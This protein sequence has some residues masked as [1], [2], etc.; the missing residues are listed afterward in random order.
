M[1]CGWNYA[2]LSS[3]K[4]LTMEDIQQCNK[5]VLQT[6][7][8]FLNTK[9]SKWVE[10]DEVYLSVF[11]L[12][13]W[14]YLWALADTKRPSLRIYPLAPTLTQKALHWLSLFCHQVTFALTWGFCA[15]TCMKEDFV[16]LSPFPNYPKACPL[17]PVSA[18]KDP[19]CSLIDWWAA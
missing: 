10:T 1:W 15:C 16:P 17:I 11:G 5:S 2:T 14:W 12:V 18:H 6:D 3:G 9:V 4:N 8:K 19:V 13:V 7:S